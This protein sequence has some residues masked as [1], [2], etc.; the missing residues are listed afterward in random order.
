[1]ICSL[2]QKRSKK[3]SSVDYTK[4]IDSLNSVITSTKEVYDKELLNFGKKQE[5]VPLKNDLTLNSISSTRIDT[6][7]WAVYNFGS[8]SPHRVSDQSLVDQWLNEHL[9]IRCT[10]EKEWQEN[11]NKARYLVPKGTSEMGYYFSLTA[12]RKINDLLKID[13]TWRIA[14]FQD[15]KAL[16][17]HA[18]NLNIKSASPFQLLVG[19][20][21]TKEIREKFTWKGQVVYDIYGLQISPFAYYTGFDDLL[22]NEG[23][24]DYFSHFS[25]KSS[26]QFYVTHIFSENKILPLELKFGDE[27]LNYG[28]FIRLI[29]I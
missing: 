12:I 4:I 10:N 17:N 15:F 1:M 13:S 29:K 7:D 20:P 21:K 3:E 14:E 8:G 9:F 19:N 22:T 25:D 26:D 23:Y 16:F 5:S 2:A 27:S 11:E 18:S 24:V 28:F 6:N